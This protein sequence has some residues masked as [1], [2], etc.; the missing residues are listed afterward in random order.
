MFELLSIIGIC[1]FDQVSFMQ[2]QEIESF[3]FGN[4][5]QCKGLLGILCELMSKENMCIVRDIVGGVIFYVQYVNV[6]KIVWRM[7]LFLF[8]QYVRVVLMQIDINV[9]DQFCVVCEVEW[10]FNCNVVNNIVNSVNVNVLWLLSFVNCL[11][12][13][14]VVKEGEC[15]MEVQLSNQVV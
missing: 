2:S 7:M 8:L 9:N 14:G 3:I 13:E 10:G 11:C 6:M 15:N 5:Q 12:N 1:R 4:Y